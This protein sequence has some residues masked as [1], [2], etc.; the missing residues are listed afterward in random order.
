MYCKYADLKTPMQA[1]NFLSSA[2]FVSVQ[3]INGVSC[4][5]WQDS[6]RN[7]WFTNVRWLQL[8]VFAV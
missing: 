4:N 6:Q 5:K 3:T 7:L 1:P 8:A 2:T